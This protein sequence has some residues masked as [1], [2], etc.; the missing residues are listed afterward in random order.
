MRRLLV[1][2]G[3][4]AWFYAP[5][6]ARATC[7]TRCEVRLVFDDCTSPEDGVWPAGLPVGLVVACGDRRY[8]PDEPPV[9]P[10]E[11][12][13]GGCMSSAPASGVELRRAS[14][15]RTLV[16]V[17]ATFREQ[18]TCL[19]WPRLEL[20]QPLSAGTYQVIQPAGLQFR[21]ADEVSAATAKRGPPVALS[22]F[23]CWGGGPPH[24]P[25]MLPPPP[26]TRTRTGC[27]VGAADAREVA[28]IGG[29]AL[30]LARRRRRGRG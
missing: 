29:L 16:P 3:A 19:G 24:E 10:T 25:Q 27:D 6:F 7:V 26:R 13:P 15:E 8:S 18:G 14:D 1:V 2:L 5:S 21:V 17:E 20:E 4:L 22:C 11:P 23:E 30:L 12:G 9:P 28:A